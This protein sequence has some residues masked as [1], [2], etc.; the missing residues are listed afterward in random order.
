MRCSLLLAFALLQPISAALMIRHA[1]TLVAGS[2]ATRPTCSP[3]RGR[4]C[5]LVTA[6]LLRTRRRRPTLH[7]RPRCSI[8]RSAREVRRRI[9]GRWN[10]EML[11]SRVIAMRARAAAP[12]A[13]RAYVPPPQSS[14]RPSPR[15][16][17]P[18]SQ[19][20]DR[21]SPPPSAGRVRSAAPVGG[22]A[23]RADAPRERTATPPPA[24][25]DSSG[26]GGQGGGARRRPPA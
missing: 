25:R 2:C 23:P 18:P 3:L 21:N 12:V 19:H 1:T 9:A 4:T 15:A 26:S 11:H 22:A 14:E 7:R 13:P 17:T 24:A 10:V 6:R 8:G 20:E 5:H 16:Y